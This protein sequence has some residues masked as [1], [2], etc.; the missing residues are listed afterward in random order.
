[1]S[2][3]EKKMDFQM[4]EN[5]QRDSFSSYGSLG[6]FG[7]YGNPFSLQNIEETEKEKI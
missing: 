1:M 6:S 7:S 5:N 3:V 2:P 4:T